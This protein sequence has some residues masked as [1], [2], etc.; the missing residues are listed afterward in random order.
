MAVYSRME[1]RLSRTEGEVKILSDRINDFAVS[2][3]AANTKLDSLLQTVGDLRGVVN[4][5]KDRPAA[6]WEKLVSGAVGAVAAGTAA[7]LM[8][9]T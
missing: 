4:R 8:G 5:I 1:H 2:Q 7:A 9:R 3:A 6:L